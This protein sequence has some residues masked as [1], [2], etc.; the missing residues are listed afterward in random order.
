MKQY[1]ATCIKKVVVKDLELVMAAIQFFYDIQ[2]IQSNILANANTYAHSDSALSCI[3]ITQKNKN[4]SDLL[5]N[6]T[7]SG[8]T[9]ANLQ[10]ILTGNRNNK[11]TYGIRERIALYSCAINNA[12]TNHSQLV[13]DIKNTIYAQSLVLA[14]FNNTIRF[15]QT[16]QKI[17]Y[18]SIKGESFKW[19]VHEPGR[20]EPVQHEAS[21]FNGGLNI[22]QFLKTYIDD[23]RKCEKT[24]DTGDVYKRY[25]FLFDSTSKIPNDAGI[26]DSKEKY[27][28]KIGDQIQPLLSNRMISNYFDFD[29]KL[30][31]LY[32]NIVK[33]GNTV[34]QF[35]P[36]VIFTYDIC[37]QLYQFYLSLFK[38]CTI[39][40]ELEY[41]MSQIGTKERIVT[42]NSV[43]ATFTLKSPNK[44]WAKAAI[45]QLVNQSEFTITYTPYSVSNFP[46]RQLIFNLIDGTVT[47]EN[48]TNSGTRWNIGNLFNVAYGNFSNT[49]RNFENS[50]DGSNGIFSYFISVED[51]RKVLKFNEFQQK[52]LE[53]INTNN[54]VSLTKILTTIDQIF[55]YWL[56]N[57]ATINIKIQMCHQNCHTNYI[58]TQQSTMV[59]TCRGWQSYVEGN[60]EQIVIPRSHGTSI[61]GEGDDEDD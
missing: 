6:T 19:K 25:Y 11:A 54:I 35:Y 13:S 38:V 22:S 60:S 58:I 18:G 44:H 48:I 51:N 55:N 59:C 40:V 7:S 20:D 1:K 45:R 43:D 21:S 5:A 26:T 10:S 27:L 15:V 8:F 46:M 41:F 49:V 30:V 3:S 33:S 57:I 37:F 4:Y 32:E 12:L 53:Y 61:R 2:Q 31:Y 34:Q 28:W 9:L 47:R 50:S 24:I 39:N 14:S 36:T 56:N 42:S 23:I 16:P 29:L 52:F 17:E